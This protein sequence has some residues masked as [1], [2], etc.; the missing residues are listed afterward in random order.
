MSRRQ[1]RIVDILKV[2]GEDRGAVGILL[3]D[4]R[5]AAWVSGDKT[6]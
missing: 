3:S 4:R 1:Y 2:V 6:R 5:Q